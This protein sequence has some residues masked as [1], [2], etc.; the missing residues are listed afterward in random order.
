MINS[1]KVKKKKIIPTAITG[2]FL[3]AIQFRMMIKTD[4]KKLVL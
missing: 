1:Q 2:V 3:P 4:Y